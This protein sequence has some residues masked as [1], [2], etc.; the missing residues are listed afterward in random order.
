[1]TQ[2][3]LVSVIVRTKNEKYWIGKCLHAI[4]NQK[5][6]NIEIIVVDNLSTD[7]TIQII[8]KNFPRVKIVKYKEKPFLPGK[9]I[10]L[11]IKKSKGKF[12][13]IISGHCIPKNY[14]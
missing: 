12:I 3:P 2:H 6:K 1:M 10:N 8:K 11:G 7:K 14:F 5:Y 9:A 13:A 4:K